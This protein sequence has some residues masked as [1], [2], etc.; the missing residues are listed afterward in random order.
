MKLDE[1]DVLHSQNIYGERPVLRLHLDVSIEESEKRYVEQIGRRL[2]KT[3]RGGLGSV[4]DDPTEWNIGALVAWTATELQ[5]SLGLELDTVGPDSDQP[6]AIAIFEYENLEVGRMAARLAFRLTRRL[7]RERS[8]KVRRELEDQIKEFTRQASG[9]TLPIQDREV[10][11]AARERGIEILP[12]AHR[13]FQLGQGRFRQRLYG[14]STS[15][16]THLSSVFAANKNIAKQLLIGAGLPVARSELVRGRR[17][18][19]SAAERIGYPVVIKPNKGSLG[20][21][22]SIGVRNSEEIAEACKIAQ[23]QGKAI[24]V[25]ELIEGL[26]HRLLIINGKAVAASMRVPAHVVGNGRSTVSEL[27]A[28]ANEDP[29]RSSGQRGAWTSLVIDDTAKRVLE[30]QGISADSVPPAGE[31]VRL[32]AV[33]NTSSG[34]TAIDITDNIHPENLRI[35]ERA[36]VALGMD[37]AGVDIL[38]TDLSRPLRETGGVICE[39]NT[40]PGLRKHIWP[41]VGK[42]RD[43]IGPLLDMLFPA[44]ENERFKTITI[45]ASDDQQPVAAI[46]RRLLERT[47]HSISTSYVDRLAPDGPSPASEHED[48]ATGAQ[49]AFLDPVADGAVLLTTPDDLM[50]RGLGYSGCSV[51]ALIGAF[52]VSDGASAESRVAALRLLSSAAREMLVVDADEPDGLELA[53]QIEGRK[54][55]VLSNPSSMTVRAHLD[56]GVALLVAATPSV[57]ET[58]APADPSAAEITIYQRGLEV[59]IPFRD[60]TSVLPEIEASPLQAAFAIAILLGLG[61]SSS[62]ILECL[63]RAAAAASA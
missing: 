9:M 19:I 25:E 51:G 50:A 5:R 55:F 37:I 10:V 32:R 7:G 2:R 46:V 1:I 3:L 17:Q 59:R 38:S 60:L 36:A 43:V 41:A 31:H 27:A 49:R 22:V 40:K 11:R 63:R 12:L 47:G 16:L 52:R 44:R 58:G 62:E 61:M 6:G 53:S 21:G 35:A 57:D 13:L 45:V 29:R 42:P 20:R 18:A 56:R 39:I 28:A 26:D 34:G 30:H 4:G 24:L 33:A 23:K 15:R 48:P 14:S 54:C 8:A